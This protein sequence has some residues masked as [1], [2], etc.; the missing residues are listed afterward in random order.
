VIALS[1]GDLVLRRMELYAPDGKLQK[2]LT[3]DRIETIGTVPTAHELVMKQPAEG[4]QTTVD[5]S[6]VRY[7]LNLPDDLFLERSLERGEQNLELS[8]G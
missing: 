6:D 4:S 8:G 5:V 7:D 2:L 1:E 3:F